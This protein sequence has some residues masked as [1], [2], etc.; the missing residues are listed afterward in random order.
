MLTEAP[1]HTMPDANAG[2]DTIKASDKK[3]CE[4][5]RIRW[6]AGLGEMSENPSD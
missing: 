4:S 5:G 2:I 3:V 6:L 1:P